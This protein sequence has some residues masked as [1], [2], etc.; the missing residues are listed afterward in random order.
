MTENP[1]EG[2]NLVSP[3]AGKCCE[4]T[5]HHYKCGKCG[6]K[7]C[8]NCWKSGE[9]YTL[10]NVGCPTCMAA[11]SFATRLGI[12]NA[13]RSFHLTAQFTAFM[14][15]HEAKPAASPPL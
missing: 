8:H 6:G 10:G 2:L 12:V 14:T 4:G 1:K 3:I 9:A 13:G 11:V 7:L 15:G 5:D